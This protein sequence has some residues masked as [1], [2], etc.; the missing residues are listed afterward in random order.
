MHKEYK[1]NILKEINTL[2]SKHSQDFWKQINKI[3]NLK[4]VEESCDIAPED[5]INHFQNLLYESHESEANGNLENNLNET[6]TL[7]NDSLD[8]PIT[9]KEIHDHI[10]KLKTKK[11]SGTDSILN[12]TRN[13]QTFASYEGN[14]SLQS[15]SPCLTGFNIQ[16]SVANIVTSGSRGSP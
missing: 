10:S 15:S 5:W 2:S 3:R 13:F 11:S 12:E 6:P 8:K 4:T 9:T 7:S 16:A 1:N 14:E